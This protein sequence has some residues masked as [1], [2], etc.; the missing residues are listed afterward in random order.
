MFRLVLSLA[1]MGACHAHTQLTRVNGN[2]AVVRK[3]S[4]FPAQS[5]LWDVKSGDMTC[6]RNAQ[7]TASQTLTV[8]AGDV[9]TLTYMHDTFRDD[10]ID[11]SHHGPCNVYM[12]KQGTE[13]NGGWF[14]IYED[15]RI[16]NGQYCTDRLI[17]NKGDLR[18]TIPSTIS[19]RYVIRGEI[20]ALHEANR[21]W[22]GNP[23]AGPGAQF[24]VHCADVQVTGGS[25]ATASP[26]VRI[27]G[28]LTQ[29]QQGVL[30][31]IYSGPTTYPRTGPAVATFGGGTAG[32]ATPTSAPVSPGTCPTGNCG[33]SWANP[34]TCGGS[35]GTVC[36]KECCCPILKNLPSPTPA[37]PICPATKCGCNWA[38]AGSCGTNDGTVCNKECCCRIR[39]GFKAAGFEVELLNA[40]LNDVDP[41]A[42]YTDTVDSMVG[43]A[44][45]TSAGS[46]LF[47]SLALGLPSVLVLVL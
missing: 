25:G 12:A 10:I 11:P 46:G 33:C 9:V 27:P 24:Y 35:D 22:T 39:K 15:I 23:N 47:V 7:V 16:T 38:N 41:N 17:A 20:A 18:V 1:L 30:F 43:M 5:P 3:F 34:S 29:N 6:G 13:N 36:N 2:G 32:G 42:S 31:N 40:T 28:H 4:N 45:P 26:M 44:S 14:K 37:P 21:P 19:G 8:A